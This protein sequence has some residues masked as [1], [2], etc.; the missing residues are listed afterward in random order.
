LKRPKMS[1]TQADSFIAQFR[2]PDYREKIR[3]F[4]APM[5]PGPNPAIRDQTI[6]EILKTPQH[7][8]VSAMEGMFAAGQPDWDPGKLTVPL[9]VLNAP[10][11][12]WTA[13]YQADLRSASANMEYRTIPGT[14]HWL[15]LEKPA[16]FNA[17]LIEMLRK[18][19]LVA[20]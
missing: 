3:A 2:G 17:A 12:R 19:G 13:A 10:S 14:G 8:I 15:M 11:E 6:D 4:L 1:P 18:Y 7:V 5:F 20:K 16:E 9:L